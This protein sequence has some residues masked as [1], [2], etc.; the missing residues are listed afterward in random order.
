M[1]F[2]TSTQGCCSSLGPAGAATC[3]ESSR[4]SRS[5]PCNISLHLKKLGVFSLLQ[6]ATQLLLTVQENDSLIF[7]ENIPIWIW[8]HPFALLGARTLLGAPGITTSSILTTRNKAMLIPSLC[9]LL[10]GDLRRFPRSPPPI[11]L[12]PQPTPRESSGSGNDIFGLRYFSPFRLL[13]L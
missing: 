10:P 8:F 2:I 3:A 4:K 5:N 11:Q 12:S 1:N 7:F 6:R 9:T 13:T